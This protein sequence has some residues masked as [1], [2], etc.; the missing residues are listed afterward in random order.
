MQNTFKTVNAYTKKV[1]LGEIYQAIE[2]KF[3]FISSEKDGNFQ[4]CPLVKCRDFLGDAIF[5]QHAKKKICIYGFSYDPQKDQKICTHQTRIL[6]Q[7]PKNT[8]K[9]QLNFISR[10][11]NC[12][13]SK[14]V[15]RGRTKWFPVKDRNGNILDKTYLFTGPSLWTSH[16]ITISL[17][18][19]IL[20][21][22]P[23]INL[24]DI[25][26]KPLGLED[27]LDIFE[28]SIASYKNNDRDGVGL[29]QKNAEMC[30]QTFEKIKWR[31]I[32][33]KSFLDEVEEKQPK[34]LIHEI[35]YKM[36]FRA[37][38]TRTT[39]SPTLN[40]ILHAYTKTNTN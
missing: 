24:Q 2:T 9:D 14:T 34:N 18:T 25:N 21:Y 29:I 5:A 39:L 15:F 12:L 38:C 30:M 16:P 17:Y 37:F 20:R 11:L 3:A 26:I 22:T 35:H 40:K 6:I 19:L 36:G 1:D 31:K 23:E 10:L 28:K 8:T 7:F 4:C 13:E 32:S 27:A 33:F